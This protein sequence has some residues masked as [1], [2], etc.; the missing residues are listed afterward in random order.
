MKIFLSVLKWIGISI[1][2]LLVLII[3]AGL[4]FRILGPDAHQPPGQ[5][6]EVG[7]NTLHIHSSGEKSQ[8]PTVVIEG[9][10]GLPSEFYHWLDAGLHD[11][12]RVVRYDRAGLGHS[13]ECM[14]PRD[15]ETIAGE[16]H[17]LLTKA[18]ESPP[19]IMMGHSLGGPYIRVFAELFPDEVDGLFF[20]DA[21]HPDHVER[22]NAPKKSSFIYK[23]YMVSIGA[24]AVLADLGILSLFDLLFG[25][26]YFGE[27]LP[28]EN[29]SRIK[30]FLKDGKSFRTFQQ[31]MEQYYSILSRSAEADDFGTMPIRV[32][33]ASSIYARTRPETESEKQYLE[34]A[35]LSTNG[36]HIQ[37]K[38]NHVTIFSKRENAQIICEEVL[39]VVRELEEE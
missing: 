19:Y 3:L 15:P 7:D 33:T 29:N 8:A 10:G 32:F 23:A 27:G 22:H 26:P 37:I 1:A 9:G 34:Y 14:T 20:L 25:T 30:D 16:L 6:V 36:E 2:S 4:S 38:G 12:L 28:D 31:E 24:E 11:S 5:L 39:Q 18:G 17:Q 13:A 21:T 35:D